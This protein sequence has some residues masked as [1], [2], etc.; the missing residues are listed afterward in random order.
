VELPRVA[1]VYHYDFPLVAVSFCVVV[2]VADS[3]F[4]LAHCR[5]NF[6]LDF[7]GRAPHLG[8]GVA[9]HV[10]DVTPGASYRLVDRALY[11]LLVHC[12]TLLT[13]S[14]SPT[15]ACR[16]YRTDHWSFAKDVPQPLLHFSAGP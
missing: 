8:S 13:S 9:G 11:S 3:I 10:S 16:L 2:C 4:H 15:T 7:L 14:Y 1:I 6:A 12:F 5:L